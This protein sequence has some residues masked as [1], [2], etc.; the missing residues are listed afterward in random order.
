M[1]CRLGGKPARLTDDLVILPAARCKRRR[2]RPTI[3]T[4][5]LSR[6][7]RTALRQREKSRRMAAD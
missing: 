6:S 4:W 3:Q 1:G 7:A 5:L 2:G